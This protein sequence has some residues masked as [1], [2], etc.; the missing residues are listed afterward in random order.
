VLPLW[1]A[2]LA[3]FSGCTG[4]RKGGAEKKLQLGADFT[5]VEKS[6]LCDLCGS[7]GI[8]EAGRATEKI[9]DFR[10]RATQKLSDGLGE[11]IC[12]V[13]LDEKRVP[14]RLRY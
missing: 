12:L 10:M 2:I 14:T 4:N 3:D 6:Q 8:G 1:P 9:A 7:R 11:Q 13:F 5:D